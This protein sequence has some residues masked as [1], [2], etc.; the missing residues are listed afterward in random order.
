MGSWLH[1]WQRIMMKEIAEDC[2][3]WQVFDRMGE[4]KGAE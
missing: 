2:Y 1:Q 3:S 4:P